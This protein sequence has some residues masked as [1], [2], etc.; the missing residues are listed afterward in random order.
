V[1][2]RVADAHIAGAGHQAHGGGVAQV[3][4][5]RRVVEVVHAGIVE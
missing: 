4:L 1:Q 3:G 2:R 5:D